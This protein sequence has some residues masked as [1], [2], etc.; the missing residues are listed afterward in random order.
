MKRIFSLAT[1]LSL[2]G[3]LGIALTLESAVMQT[4]CAATAKKS[5]V[6]KKKVEKPAEKPP[7]KA[8]VKPLDKDQLPEISTTSASGEDLEPAEL[9]RRF[10]KQANTY[11]AMAVKREKAGRIDEA[12]KLYFRSLATRQRVWGDSDPATAEII[13]KI[14]EIHMKRGRVDSAETCYKRCLS[15]LSKRLGPGSYEIVPSLNRLA[16]IATKHKK[17]QEAY[18]YS[19][20]A[21]Q[22]QERKTGPDSDKTIGAR[23]NLIEAALGLHDW[24]EAEKQLKLAEQSAANKKDDHSNNYVRILEDYATLCSATNRQNEAT[25]YLSKA[26]SLRSGGVGAPEEPEAGAAEGNKIDAAAPKHASGK[27][28]SRP[29]KPHTAKK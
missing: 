22:L 4:A 17:F 28:K 23:L 9:A 25:S 19:D 16:E 26:A 20:R 3:S 8:N 27:S 21:V 10:G 2:S 7:V 6:T 24:T 12:Q 5:A 11:Y 18:D 13:Y 14:A 29:A 15:I 1:L